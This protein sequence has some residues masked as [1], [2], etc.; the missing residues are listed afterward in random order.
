MTRQHCMISDQSEYGMSNIYLDNDQRSRYSEISIE[1]NRSPN[2]QEDDTDTSDTQSYLTVD[3][4]EEYKKWFNFLFSATGNLSNR[5]SSCTYQESFE[6]SGLTQCDCNVTEH[7]AIRNGDGGNIRFTGAVQLIFDGTLSSI[8]HRHEVRLI[9]DVFFHE[10][11]VPV[12]QS[13]PTFFSNSFFVLRSFNCLGLTL[14]PSLWR[15]P[16]DSCLRCC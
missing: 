16:G 12:S 14:S 11:Q 2:W 7:D 5:Y 9:L 4:K 15:V 13:T 3:L 6:G 10:I 8:S 1:T